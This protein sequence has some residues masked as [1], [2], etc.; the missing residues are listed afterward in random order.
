MSVCHNLQ[1]RE[2]IMQYDP[3]FRR[4]G[5]KILR[6][7]QTVQQESRRLRQPLI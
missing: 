5:L 6:Q 3:H 2:Q 7:F 1:L 4:R